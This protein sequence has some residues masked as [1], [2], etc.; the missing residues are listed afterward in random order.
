M[1]L[2]AVNGLRDKCAELILTD[3][4]IKEYMKRLLEDIKRGLGKDTHAT[5]VVKSFVTYV[6][7][8]PDG[9]GKIFLKNFYSN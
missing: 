3:E 2:T 8:L 4:Q 9:T 6:Q 7:D 5:A 1:V